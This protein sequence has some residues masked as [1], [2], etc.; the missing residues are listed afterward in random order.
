MIRVAAAYA[1]KTADV[2]RRF[3]A[4][5]IRWLKQERFRD[6]EPTN[7]GDHPGRPRAAQAEVTE[8]G[9]AAA[10]GRVQERRRRS[11]ALAEGLWA[12]SLACGD[13]R[14][15]SSSRRIWVRL[16]PGEMWG[17]PGHG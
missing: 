10:A 7:L 8:E 16:M 3:I 2:D 17:S 5:A 11:T 12:A 4:Q 13:A 1:A 14:A 9:M 6:E 15:E